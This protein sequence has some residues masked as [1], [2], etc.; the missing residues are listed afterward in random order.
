MEY[1]STIKKNEV[2]IH[3]TIWVDLKN[4]QSERIQTQKAMYYMIPFIWNIQNRQIHK[5]RLV[6]TKEWGKRGI[7]SEYLM[8]IGFPFWVMKMFWNYICNIIKVF[9]AIK[10]CTL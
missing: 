9:N 2:L 3:A 5:D 4:M 1:Y 10:N 7:G 6:V 8:N